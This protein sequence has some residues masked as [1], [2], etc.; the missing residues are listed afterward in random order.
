MS[1]PTIAIK[2]RVNGKKIIVEIDADRFERLAAS[3]GFF[4]PKFLSSLDRAE[5]DF[6]AGRIRKILSLGT[7]KK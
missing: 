1:L 4:S 2:P 5:R 7:L 6:K 3:L